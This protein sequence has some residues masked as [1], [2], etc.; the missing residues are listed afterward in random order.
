MERKN[1]LSCNTNSNGNNL[2]F[3][4]SSECFKEEKLKIIDLFKK[5]VN[6]LLTAIYTIATYYLQKLDTVYIFPIIYLILFYSALVIGYKIT[7]NKTNF[8]LWRE[9]QIRHI[10]KAFCALIFMIYGVL[11]FTKLISPHIGTGILGLTFC[12]IN[13]FMLT[14]NIVKRLA[15]HN[16]NR[17][18]SAD[19]TY[20]YKHQKRFFLYFFKRILFEIRGY[21]EQHTIILEELSTSITD[22]IES[23]NLLIQD[24]TSALRE[25]PNQECPYKD[26]NKKEIDLKQLGIKP[27]DIENSQGKTVSANE[28]K[29]ILEKFKPDFNSEQLLRRL[30]EE[31]IIKPYKSKLSS[32]SSGKYYLSSVIEYIKSED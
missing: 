25:N 16:F 9:P 2:R 1:C 29:Q 27:E 6:L 22:K 18:S 3:N 23:N 26:I 15:E 13:F 21:K 17:H 8:F 32:K 20:L 4:N 28:L 24:I 31:N 10:I 14:N 30:R 7:K 11:L 12:L 5:P 19:L